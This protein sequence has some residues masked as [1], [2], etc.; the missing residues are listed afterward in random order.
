MT[1]TETVTVDQLADA[2][3]ANDRDRVRQIL[4][5]RPD[6]IRTD[7]A[8]EN[9]HQVLHY[10]VYARFPEMVRLL[11]QR[12]ANA[13]KGVWP[14]RAAT[15]AFVIA[16]DRDYDEIVAIIEEEE[17]LR[18][19]QA[20]ADPK[21]AAR[22]ELI[23]AF[24]R[25]DEGAILRIVDADPSLI[26]AHWWALNAAAGKCFERLAA[27]LLEHGYDVNSRSGDRTPLDM[28]AEC[29]PYFSLD[30]ARKMMVW[31]R[32]HG[33][34]LT[35]RAAVALGE[36]EWLRTRYADGKL[37]NPPTMK[38]D[39]AYG[40]LL[41]IAAIN[42]HLDMVELLL[43]LGF[44]PDE[45]A[46]IEGADRDGWGGPL[47]ECAH[48]GRLAIAETLLKR[49][50]DPNPK[51]HISKTPIACAYE[52][53]DSAM[54]ELLERYRAIAHPVSVGIAGN[55]EKAKNLIADEAAGQLPPGFIGPQET[56]GDLL[57]WSGGA[58]GHPEIVRL[59]LPIFNLPRDDPRWW[60]MLW[61]PL[62]RSL[63]C[64]TLVLQCCNPDAS[65]YFG[66]TILHD[67][68]GMYGR[69]RNREGRDSTGDA[70]AFASAVLDAGG[71]LDI[72]DD[73]LKSTPLGWACRW[74]LADLVKLFL[75]RGADPV[76][77]DAEPW[78]T[79]RAWA[80][81]MHHQEI[82]ELVNVARPN[83]SS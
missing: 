77:A 13:R 82:V 44:D 21:A 23:K 68:V 6:L 12:G 36:T 33:A 59:A 76:E 38:A 80:E 74:G 10:A 29:A 3:K 70:I 51:P 30:R 46:P 53:R 45:R 56:L 75:D 32:E 34:E 47:D 35:P 49:G 62:F 72:R 67:I 73:L 63:E 55:L 16:G 9:E 41:E 54:I 28:A 78:A 43:E 69:D 31:L 17:N 66:R 81:K 22:Q 39:C 57:L 20:P 79:P 11:M 8:Y 42:D 60:W 2:V 40:G 7:M 18:K 19:A 48:W 15:T 24:D 1:P 58:G 14:H 4:D 37:A 83:V 65:L 61:H 26:E 64:F 50:A 27:W 71:R 5:A 25:N 52:K